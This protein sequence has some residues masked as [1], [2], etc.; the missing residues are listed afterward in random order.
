MLV[1][2]AAA[3]ITALTVGSPR[4]WSG[5]FLLVA[6]PGAML[7]FGLVMLG[8][9]WILLAMWDVSERW[10]VVAACAAVGVIGVVAAVFLYGGDVVGSG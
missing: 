1:T 9:A 3:G 2:L 6:A 10:S 7:G 5:L 8:V 4:R